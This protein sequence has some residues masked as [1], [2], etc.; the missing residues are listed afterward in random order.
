MRLSKTLLTLL[1]VLIP[2]TGWGMECATVD[3]ADSKGP[4]FVGGSYMSRCVNKE[5]VCYVTFKRDSGNGISCIKN[6]VNNSK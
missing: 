3:R 1:L 5:V 6:E 4:I 2:S